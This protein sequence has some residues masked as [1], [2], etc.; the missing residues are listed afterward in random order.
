MIEEL[1]PREVYLNNIISFQIN[2]WIIII[3]LNYNI[4]FPR[5]LFVN[6]F[7]QKTNPFKIY[8]MDVL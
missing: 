8:P 1:R 5:L 6:V 2:Y 7:R 3:M 4:I